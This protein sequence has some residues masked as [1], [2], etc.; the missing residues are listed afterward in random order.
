[1]L[2]NVTKFTGINVSSKVVTEISGHPNI[3]GMKDSSGNISQLVHFQKAALPDYQVL[4]GTAG[5]WYPALTLGVTAAVMALA[6][7]AP[8]ECVQI[9]EYYE[10]GQLKEA[11]ALYRRMV[12]LN[13]AITATF[14]IAG[15][16]YVCSKIGLKGGA[17]RSPLSELT[18]DEKNRLDAIVE[19]AGCLITPSS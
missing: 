15:L 7:C 16:K 9:Q 3:I 18:A 6:N 13:T 11:E 1:M 14:G 8:K 19:E 2:Y 10:A 12:P 4:T 5:I 17:V